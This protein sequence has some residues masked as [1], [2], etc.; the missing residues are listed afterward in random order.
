[1]ETSTMNELRQGS[2]DS[3]SLAPIIGFALGAV[4]GAGIA[5]LL[6]PASGERTRRRIGDA[7][8]RWSRDA[9]QTFDNA[10]EAASGLG[11]DVKSAIDAGR[12]AFRHE[13][14]P[15]TPRSTSRIAQTLDPPPVA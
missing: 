13:G 7:A 1:M 3:R 9:R 8:L 15:H 12:E 4:V 14:E 2:D 11:D 10:R 6:A 5:L